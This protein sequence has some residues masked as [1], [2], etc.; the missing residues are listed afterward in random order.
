MQAGQQKPS[1]ESVATE[2]QALD[3]VLASERF[4]RAPTLSGILKYVCEKHFSGQ[5]KEIKEYN[6]AVEALGRPADFDP[7]EHSVVRVEASRLRKRLRQY[8]ESEGAQDPIR[9]RLAKTGYRPHF[10]R[11][12]TKAAA[13]PSPPSPPAAASGTM[14]APESPP[15]LGVAWK[16]AGLVLALAA[17]A[18]V[19]FIIATSRKADTAPAL[20]A[21]PLTAYRGREIEPALS[22]AGDRVAFVWEGS[23]RDNFDVYVK[24]L[25]AGD[26][27]RLTTNP[28]EDFSPI[29]SPDGQ[30]IVFFRRREGEG[31][32]LIQTP[33]AGGAEVRLAG[34]YA[35][36][37]WHLRRSGP[38]AAWSP[39]PKSIVIVDRTSRDDPPALFLF[40]TVTGERRRLTI[41]PANSN[42]H[43]A[44]S[45]SPGGGSLVYTEM[46]GPFEHEIFVLDLD[47]QLNPA[48]SP[49]QV[50]FD[51][52]WN[53]R[54]VWTPSGEEI[55]FSRSGLWRIR[56]R[57]GPAQAR[58]LA[59]AGSNAQYPSLHP[60]RD[61]LVFSESESD[62]NIW[63]ARLDT[64][65]SGSPAL[66]MLIG[67][68]RTDAQPR[69]SPDGRKI[70]FISTRSGATEIWVCD[71]SGENASRLTNLGRLGAPHWSP[72]GSQIAFDHYPAGYSDIYVIDETGRGLRR[73][74]NDRSNNIM[75]SWSRN[76]AWI[77]FGSNRSGRFQ[78]WRV[79]SEGG[80]PEVVTRNNGVC[81]LESED[82]R[83]L[84]FA[85]GR[86]DTQ[87][88]VK[89]FD[90][91]EER[92]LLEAV[93]YHG[94]TVAGDHVYFIEGG[95]NKTEGGTIRRL[96]WRNNTVETLL[97]LEKP[98][99]IGVTVSPDESQLLFSQIDRA[100]AD[101]MLVRNFR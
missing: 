41:P 19:A 44:P 2:R 78:V 27:L 10:D 69:I 8:Y 94:F 55:V 34:V 83:Q 45:F 51:H 100:T 24:P 65:G 22:P 47:K 81:G 59:F 42:G 50:T 46:L 86:G 18:G 39:D 21:V 99:S 53:R 93:N 74:T 11:L 92:P 70:A 30:Y 68:S 72:D 31:A 17:A 97:T 82:G 60:G 90:S 64:P 79:P 71:R 56:A 1:P 75:P 91:G 40:S 84:F 66:H 26:P 89:D 13:Q 73:L 57:G 35:P 43:S 98:L 36:A 96:N 7:S 58:R 28:A 76:G 77:Y 23:A 101:L 15:P 29:W 20:E 33:S 5:A 80:E 48:G 52:N 9:V 37:A 14:P 38:L 6:I 54:P 85:A 63:S 3:R 87:L 12:D 61:I 88:W 16:A 67:S 49:K 32:D 62:Q 95:G 4:Q 25:G